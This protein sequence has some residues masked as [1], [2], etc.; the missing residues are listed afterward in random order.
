MLS[1]I[2]NFLKTVNDAMG[3]QCLGAEVTFPDGEKTSIPWSNDFARPEVGAII[4][5]E[6]QKWRVRNASLLEFWDYF[7]EV[8]V[9][10]A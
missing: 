2:L 3:P 6:N 10:P 1:K 5:I 4:E 9:E 8:A 7:W